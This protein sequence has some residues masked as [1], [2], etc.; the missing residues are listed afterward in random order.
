MSHFSLHLAEFAATLR[1]DDIPAAAREAASRSLLDIL[2]VAIRGRQHEVAVRG[3]DGA[4]ALQRGEGS[5]VVWGTRERLQPLAAVMANGIAAHVDD[6]DDTHSDAIVHGSAVIAPVVLALAAERGASGQDLLA[7]FVAGWEVAAR[8]G[9]AAR[10]SF[11][12]RG[13]HTTSIAGI[14]GA[15]A[16][17]ARLMGLDAQRTAHALGLAG[18]QASGINEYLSN[19]SSSKTLHCGWSA[20]GAIVAATLARAGMTGPMSVFEGRY[21]LLRAYGL[22]ER[23]DPAALDRGLGSQWEVTRISIK[24][25]PCC[26]YAHAFV[27]CAGQLLDRGVTVEQIGSIECVVHEQQA[28]MVCEPVA[29][30]LEP[31]TPYVAKFSLPFLV[32]ARLLDGR[33]EHATFAA[34]NLRR[35]DLLALARRVGYRIAAEGETRFPETFPGRLVATLADGRQV[36]ERLDVNLGHPG[37]PLSFD[38]VV[39]KFSANATAALGAAGA[40]RVVASVRRLPEIDAASL[41]AALVPN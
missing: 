39:A 22:P 32:A 40:A 17:A 4:R 36:E 14:F 27:D 13:F 38:Q 29:D 28:P 6:F 5:A 20:Q 10:G 37:H 31:A 35:P 9:L 23:A 33:I 15:T 16:A 11:H 1:F 19:G 12:Q 30:K 3:L 21:G 25:Y 7:A 26:H 41:A 18:S 2:G 8:V 34:D 24:P